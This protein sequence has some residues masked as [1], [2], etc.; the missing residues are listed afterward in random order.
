MRAAFYNSTELTASGGDTGLLAPGPK[1]INVLAEANISYRFDQAAL[2]GSTLRL[3]RQTLDIPYVNKQDIRML[4]I[5]HEG[6]TIGGQTDDFG[7]IA[8]HITKMKDYDSDKFVHMSEAAGA[9]DT[10]KGV[11]IAGVRVPVTPRLR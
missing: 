9:E 8:G 6:Y 1:N 10:R 7:D 5:T 4:P 11:S 3:Y 2:K